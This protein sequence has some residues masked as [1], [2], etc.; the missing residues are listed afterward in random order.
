MKYKL[1]RICA[2]ASILSVWS[3]FATA[4]VA[5]DTNI[6]E[7]TALCGLIELGAGRALLK[8]EEETATGTI[9]DIM[10][11][12]MSLSDE[13]W[14][15]MFREPSNPEN[16]RDLPKS[17]FTENKDWP[18]KWPSWKAAA[19]RLKTGQALD[20][21]R[22][23]A[24]LQTADDA[25]LKQAIAA[26]GH[27]AETVAYLAQEIS[28]I[29]SSGK[30]LKQQQ[31]RE[32]LDKQIYGATTDNEDAVAVATLL[33]SAH[34]GSHQATCEGTTTAGKVTT[35]MAVMLCVC[36]KDSTASGSEGKACAGKTEL[37][38]TWNAASAPTTTELGELINLCDTKA[39]VQLTST[40]LQTQINNAKKLLRRTSGGTYLGKI[41]GSNCDGK[42]NGGL[43]V[44]YTG[45]TTGSGI[46]FDKIPW[47]VGL[48]QLV[49]KLKVS[50]HAYS[51][52]RALVR[53]LKTVTKKLANIGNKARQSAAATESTK[54]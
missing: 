30:I 44:K 4:N 8:E 26:A 12:N 41:V 46:S 10:D 32:S 5:E 49:T 27:L 25:T 7:A 1:V 54:A 13:S 37:T 50:E 16:F 42:N 19:Q 29:D 33:R 28:E 9:D 35:V 48:Q 38:N 23:K 21:I 18:A 53:E 6:H 3:I 52:K 51:I 2:V 24:G 17:E 31:I 36:S 20:A 43:C 45:I 15:K 22:K 47:L 40:E 39:V 14:R 34:S 11:L